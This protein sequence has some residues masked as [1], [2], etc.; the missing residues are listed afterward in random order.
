LE[1]LAEPELR[2]LVKQAAAHQAAADRLRVRQDEH[3]RS[4]AALARRKQALPD[5]VDEAKTRLALATRTLEQHDRPLRR[6]GHTAEIASAKNEAES[7]PGRIEDLEREMDELPTKIGIER[8]ARDQANEL[9][10]DRHG[11][12]AERV[13][14]ALDEDARIRGEHS[15]EQPSQ[16]L[17]DHL[18]PVPDEPV[19][20]ERWVT[21][22]GRAAQHRALWVLPENTLV[23]PLPPLGQPDYAVTYYAVN[24]AVADLVD[25]V[26]VPRPGQE[27]SAPGL[28]L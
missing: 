13:R 8:A 26:V 1:Q 2:A 24:R 15:A 5:L 4:L 17:T 3:G 11:A 23:G 19:A 28:S 18:G 16:F 7:L 12:D 27:R 14:Q 21:A 22:A 6:R 10:A 25:T 9:H 20:R